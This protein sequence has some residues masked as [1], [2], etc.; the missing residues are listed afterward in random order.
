MIGVE[1]AHAVVAVEPGL[2]GQTNR[3]WGGGVSYDADV[4]VESAL[5]TANYSSSVG[6]GS[7]VAGVSADVASSGFTSA[8]A[9]FCSTAGVLGLAENSHALFSRLGRLISSSPSGSWR[10]AFSSGI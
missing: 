10:C 1:E 4:T 9:R 3:L 6:G 5:L 2:L 7:S 8:E